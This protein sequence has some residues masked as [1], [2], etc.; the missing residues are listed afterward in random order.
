MRCNSATA[1]LGRLV[2]KLPYHAQLGTHTHTH[3]RTYLNEW[4]AR[5]KGHCIEN[6]QA[7]RRTSIPSAGFKPAFLVVMRLQL[8]ALDRTATEIGILLVRIYSAYPVISWLMCRCCFLVTA[9][10]HRRCCCA[11]GRLVGWATL[12]RETGWQE[13]AASSCRCEFRISKASCTVA[14]RFHPHVVLRL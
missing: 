2:L 11:L 14:V 8:R 6:K 1:G 5:R 10:C 7:Q 13:V 4:S 3:G 12:K 9:A